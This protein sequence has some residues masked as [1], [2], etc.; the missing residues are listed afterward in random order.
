[1]TTSRELMSKK[2][3]LEVLERLPED[4]TIDDAIHR[5]N[6]LKAVT[7]GLAQSE[8]GLGKDHDELFDELLNEEPTC[9]P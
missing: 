5:L 8:K 4:A 6:F 3:I 2:G 9:A 1:M 7:T